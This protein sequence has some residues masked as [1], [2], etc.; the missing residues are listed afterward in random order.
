MDLTKEV[1][2]VENDVNEKEKEL[3][4]QEL[5]YYAGER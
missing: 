1:A 3:H 2:K 4:Q 5:K